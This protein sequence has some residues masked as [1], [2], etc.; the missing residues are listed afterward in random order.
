MDIKEN[1]RQ[2]KQSS[3][4]LAALPEEVRN[5]AL[6][7]VCEALTSRQAQ[8]LEANQMDLERAEATQLA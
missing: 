7:A 1:I 8:I 4:V 5:G 3:Y 6:E 2:V